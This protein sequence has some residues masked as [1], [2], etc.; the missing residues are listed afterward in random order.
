MIISVHD[1][2]AFPF[3]IIGMFF[4]IIVGFVLIS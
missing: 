4:S 1:R 3:I 2:V